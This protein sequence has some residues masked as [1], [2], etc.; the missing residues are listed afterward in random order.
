MDNI[1]AKLLKK[2]KKVTEIAL[3][4]KPS[5]TKALSSVQRR[6]KDLSDKAD[7][8]YQLTLTVPNS[9]DYSITRSPFIK[10]E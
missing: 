10:A 9:G 3:L 1:G 6:Q 8:V 4:T 2:I 5:D 7:S